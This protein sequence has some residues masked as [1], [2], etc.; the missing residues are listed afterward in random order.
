MPANAQDFTE[1]VLANAETFGYNHLI[2]NCP[3]V[4]N[5]DPANAGTLIFA[6][7]KDLLTNWS[8]FDQETIQK[9]ENTVWG[10]GTWEVP[11]ELHI[12]DLSVASGDVTAGG[13]RLTAKGRSCHMQRKQLI[14]MAHQVEAVVSLA[15][16]KSLRVHSKLYTWMIT[17]TGRTI[18]SG[19]TL[20][21][22]ALNLVRPKIR[23]SWFAEM[24]EMR[25]LN[26]D[27]FHG[28]AVR[29]LP[30]MELKRS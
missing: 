15:Y 4:A 24:D 21:F 8:S 26:L 2:T 28:D 11:D 19:L 22:H 3:T 14:W 18:K 27:K 6:E 16:K 13:T 23:I 17:T 5:P 29:L 20:L 12:E 30:T 10:D 1:E 7:R 25:K 9:F